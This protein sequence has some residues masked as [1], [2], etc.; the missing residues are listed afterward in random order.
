MSQAWAHNLEPVAVINTDLQYEGAAAYEIHIGNK[1]KTPNI[2]STTAAAL[3]VVNFTSQPPS[4]RHG[5]PRVVMIKWY[6]N[7]AFAG[8]TGNVNIGLIQPGSLGATDCLRAF[9]M[10]SCMNNLQITINNAQN[11]VPIQQVLMPMLNCNTYQDEFAHYLSGCPSALDEYQCYSDNTQP[12]APTSA[13]TWTLPQLY[14]VTQLGGNVSDPFQAFG[15]IDNAFRPNRGSFPIYSSFLPTISATS[16]TLQYEIYEPILISPF[17]GKG[18]KDPIIGINQF[19]ITCNF[20]SNM[21]RIW[22]RKFGTLGN[23]ILQSVQVSFFKQPELHISWLTPND[24]VIIPNPVIYDF[25]NLDVYPQT[26]FAS[27]TLD[28]VTQVTT[29]NIQLTQIPHRILIYAQRQQNSLSVTGLGPT[30]WFETDTF[31]NIQRCTVNFDNRSGIN[32]NADSFDLWQQ[33]VY[34]GLQMSWQQWSRTRGSVYILDVTKNLTLTNVY[35]AP[36]QRMNKQ[37]NAQISFKNICVNSTNGF[38]ATGGGGVEYNNFPVTVYVV[39]INNGLLTIDS[40][41]AVL[42]QSVT[43]TTDVSKA[44]SKLEKLPEKPAIDM[45][46]GGIK[47]IGKFFSKLH[48]GLKSAK[49]I[50]TALNIGQALSA[51]PSLSGYAPHPAFQ[52]AADVLGYGGGNASTG[53]GG[54]MISREDLYKR[55]RGARSFDYDDDDDDDY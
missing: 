29:Q 12:A 30:P 8:Q 25:S 17:V 41:N 43:S 45:Y 42:Q 10:M 19:N 34:N 50:S 55:A 33:S 40:G 27:G 20:G 23:T 1:D 31:L 6:V 22:S 13:A 46:G 54:Q 5:L 35:E 32:A 53:R 4:I 39:V 38:V 9:P 48:Q 11:N 24:S 18:E 52:A 44:L 14:Q 49:P 51:H 28:T 26:T 16:G 37:F 2:I 7:I 21:G 47:R 36:G 15:F 3:P